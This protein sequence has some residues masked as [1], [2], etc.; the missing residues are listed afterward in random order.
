MEV[1]YASS[2]LEETCL[3]E[4]AGNK[5]HGADVAKIIRKRIA[6]LRAAESVADLLQ[7]LGKWHPLSGN[8]DNCWATHLT[9][10]WRLIIRDASPETTASAVVIEVVEI[11]DYH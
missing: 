10:N 5:S 2:K 11:V 4:R 7:G 3:V 8:Y 1:V 9:K 6:Q